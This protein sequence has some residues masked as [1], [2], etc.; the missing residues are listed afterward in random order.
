MK[1]LSATTVWKTKAWQFNSE[2]WQ[3]EDDSGDLVVDFGIIRHPGAV[4]IVPVMGDD[5]LLIKQFRPPL[6]RDIL[7]LP[8]GTLDGDEDPL[9][10]A[11]RELREETGY[12]AETFTPLGA[13]FPVPGYS[14]EEMHFYLA[15]NLDPDSL[16]QD[17]DERIEVIPT[18]LETALATAYAGEYE[19]MKTMVGLIRAGT[20]IGER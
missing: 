5:V 4:V 19:D 18:P 20:I 14:T 3:I 16:P 12:R 17:I 6:G 11:Q 15:E 9:I 2:N 10:A 7:E 8:A 13:F 1:K